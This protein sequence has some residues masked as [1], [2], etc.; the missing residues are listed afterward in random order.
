MSVADALVEFE[1]T[2]TAVNA[3]VVARL[4]PGLP[5]ADVEQL[6]RNSGFQPNDDLIDLWSW[7][8]GTGG[9]LGRDDDSDPLVG[10]WMFPPLATALKVAND[11]R[12]NHLEYDDGESYPAS[13]VP[14]LLYLGW[15]QAVM[16]TQG[17]SRRVYLYEEGGP[18]VLAETLEELV[19]GLT[20]AVLSTG[21]QPLSPRDV[22]RDDLPPEARSLFP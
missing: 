6:F 8:D 12:A 17:D 20:K 22:F 19:L 9:L 18:T 10:S 7:R 15:V 4:R 3:P 2:L 11:T 16:D 14:V 21:Y 13:W 5:R 1:R